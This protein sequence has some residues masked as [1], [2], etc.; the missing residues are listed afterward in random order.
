MSLGVLAK[1]VEGALALDDALRCSGS[2]VG[3]EELDSTTIEVGWGFRRADDYVLIDDVQVL[4]W[5]QA[6]LLIW[7]TAP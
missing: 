5:W 3:V 1:A 2:P 7:P 4:R 6:D